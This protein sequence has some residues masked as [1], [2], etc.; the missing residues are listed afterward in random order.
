[1]EKNDYDMG[2]MIWRAVFVLV[3]VFDVCLWVILSAA[4]G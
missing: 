4:W 1:M 3:L 2:E